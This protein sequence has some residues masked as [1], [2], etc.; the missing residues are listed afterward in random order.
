MSNGPDWQ[1][2]DDPFEHGG[3]RTILDPSIYGQVGNVG[4]QALQRTELL[5]A[6][7][8]APVSAWLIFTSQGM[9]FGEMVRVMG[10]AFLIGRA[11]DCDLILEDSAVSRQHAKIRV[12]G[13]ADA[14][15]YVIHDLATDNGTFVNNARQSPVELQNGDLIRIGRTE[16]TFK[17]LD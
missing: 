9:R 7:R 4:A 10:G 8:Q 17:R 12:E 5:D 1:S 14:P 6:D 13:P 16:L 15:R 2:P 11:P 3:D